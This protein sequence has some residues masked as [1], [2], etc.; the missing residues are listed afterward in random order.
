MH[1]KTNYNRQLLQPIWLC[2][3]V[4][5]LLNLIAC[6]VGIASA[7]H[8]GVPTDDLDEVSVDELF[9]VRVTSVGHEAQELSKVSGG[10]VCPDC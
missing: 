6:A 9:N 2:V 1:P 4:V 7:Q 5:S 10:G 3:R 8:V